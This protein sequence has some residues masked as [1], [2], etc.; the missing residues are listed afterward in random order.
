MTATAHA[1]AGAA[2]AVKISNPIIG[3][4]I[5]LISHFLLDLVP[6]WDFGTNW[7]KKTKRLLWLQS[8]LDVLLGFG[9]V[10]WLFSGRVDPVYLWIMVIFAQLPDWL[11]VPS[12]FMG[13]NV[14][15]FSWIKNLQTTIHNR[16]QLPWGLATQGIVIILVVWALQIP[17]VGQVLAAVFPPD[18]TN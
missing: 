3:L 8:T 16:L 15:P 12:L 11:E 4:P 10:L 7:K 13:F 1:L 14:P 9:L 5:A 2:L 18:L 6:H 17:E